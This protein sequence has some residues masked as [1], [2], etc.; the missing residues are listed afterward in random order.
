MRKSEYYFSFLSMK[1]WEAS[2]VWPTWSN[3]KKWPYKFCKIICLIPIIK[4]QSFSSIFA[5]RDFITVLSTVSRS[6]TSNESSGYILVNESG[7]MRPQVSSPVKTVVRFYRLSDQIRLSSLILPIKGEYIYSI[8]IKVCFQI[9]EW[10]YI[11][12]V[13]RLNSLKCYSRTICNRY[14]NHSLI[15]II[16]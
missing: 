16:F 3:P 12:S 2:K 7:N 14:E 4:V 8:C 9:Y 13:Y 6:K 10:R 11:S 15:R 1:G 5:F